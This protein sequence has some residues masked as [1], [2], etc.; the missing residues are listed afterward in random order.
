MKK[1]LLVL[2]A[3]LGFAL[4]AAAIVSPTYVAI[5]TF[6]PSGADAVVAAFQNT[7][8]SKDV[9]IV[10]IEIS[11]ASTGT[12]TGGLMQFFVYGSTVV[13]AGSTVQTSVY[14]ATSANASLPSGI[15]FSLSPTSIQYENKK[16]MQL[17]LIRPLIVNNDETATANFRDAWFTPGGDAEILQLPHGSSRAIVFVQKRLGT[18][19]ITDGRVMLVITYTTK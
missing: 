11:G 19:D 10:S 6:T 18:V 2:L 1:K 8:A 5:A 9:R 15:S 17:P 12:Y 16:T 4:P 14:A 7:S 3:V 13:T